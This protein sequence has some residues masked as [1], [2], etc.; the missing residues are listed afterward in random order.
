MIGSYEIL[1]NLDSIII[2]KRDN[3]IVYTNTNVDI[4]KLQDGRATSK[5]VI[6]RDGN[7]YEIIVYP[8]VDI[9]HYDSLTGLYSKG[10][11][12]REAT[13]YYNTTL[14]SKEQFCVVFMDL[15]NF[16]KINDTFGHLNADKILKIIGTCIKKNI[17]VTDL[18]TRF[19]GD[20]F[21][22]LLKSANEDV[23][24]RIVEEIRKKINMINN[25]FQQSM[26][27]VTISVSFGIAHSST[28]DNFEQV[29]NNA[30]MALY[31]AKENKGSIEIFEGGKQI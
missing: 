10:T 3:Q 15:D 30:D 16:K 31:K 5:S 19:G 11:F 6:A 9:K 17:R 20:E 18:C 13:N 28:G 14:S 29:L 26:D 7:K 21:I 25:E 2:V 22:I 23:T 12:E 1:K 27:N 4:S 24:I 8:S